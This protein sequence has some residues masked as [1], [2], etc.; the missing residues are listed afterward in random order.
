MLAFIFKTL[1]SI[2]YHGM[3]AKISTAQTKWDNCIDNCRFS[4]GEDTTRLH[5]FEKIWN[6]TEGLNWILNLIGVTVSLWYDPDKAEEQYSC[7]QCLETVDLSPGP[8]KIPQ[9]DNGKEFFNSHI[10]VY[11]NSLGFPIYAAVPAIIHTIK[12]RLNVRTRHWLA[13]VHESAWNR[14]KEVDLY[15]RWDII[16]I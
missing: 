13:T 7:F 6:P 4:V 16:Y 15:F 5:L 14:W 11:V 8:P 12:D 3:F 10:P 1:K 2:F 9:S